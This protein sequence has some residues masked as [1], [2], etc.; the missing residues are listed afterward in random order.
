MPTKKPYSH[1][2]LM[3]AGY[4][5]LYLLLKAYRFPLILYLF[6]FIRFFMNSQ[7][8]VQDLASD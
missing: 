5:F 8:D 3:I 6:N 7:L 2:S 1:D 4:I